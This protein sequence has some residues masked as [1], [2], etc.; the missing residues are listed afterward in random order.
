MQTWLPRVVAAA[1]VLM[2]V[3]FLGFGLINGTFDRRSQLGAVNPL[4]VG[5]MLTPMAYWLLCAPRGCPRRVLYVRVALWALAFLAILILSG[6]RMSALVFLAMSP[7]GLIFV[8]RRHP[9]HRAMVLW[10]AAAAAAGIV[11]ISVCIQMWM[12]DLDISRRLGLLLKFL[13]GDQSGADYSIS[14]RLDIWKAAI[15]AIGEAPLWGY[16][17]QNEVAAFAPHMPDGATTMAHAHNQY[18]SFLLGGGYP[19]LLAGVAFLCAPL[20]ALLP[21]GPVQRSDASIYAALILVISWLLICLT[22][23][24]LTDVRML[25]FYAAASLFLRSW[26]ART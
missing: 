2:L 7:G 16:G 23:S 3:E 8:C 20:L 22:D 5:A 24:Y 21:G 12:P 11:L 26:F 15:A 1:L 10:L 17:T 14:V 9:E 6:A 13:S 19:A 18:L 25:A 4:F